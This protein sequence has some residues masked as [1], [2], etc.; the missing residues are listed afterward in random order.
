[1]HDAF[2]MHISIPSAYTGM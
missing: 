1:M 2:G